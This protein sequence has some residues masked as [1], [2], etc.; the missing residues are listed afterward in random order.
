MLQRSHLMQGQKN[1]LIINLYLFYF[2]CYFCLFI[3][4]LMQDR[5]SSLWKHSDS[6]VHQTKETQ[7]H[8]GATF[9][10][11][12]WNGILKF[13]QKTLKMSNLHLH[14]QCWSHF[15]TFASFLCNSHK[16]S[17]PPVRGSGKTNY[18]RQFS[19]FLLY[20]ISF[21]HLKKT[22]NNKISLQITSVISSVL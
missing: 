3:G 18:L 15:P 7:I 9:M 1:E 11:V 6:S 20:V 8:F 5:H 19:Q 21:F 22:E 13:W 10:Q 4:V 12:V 17:N 14:S 2:C 16:K